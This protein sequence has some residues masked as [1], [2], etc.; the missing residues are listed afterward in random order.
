[1]AVLKRFILR[2]K[3][4]NMHLARFLNYD[5]NLNSVKVLFIDILVLVDVVTPMVTMVS[6]RRMS[7][8]QQRSDCTVQPNIHFVV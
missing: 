6:A 5:A 2:E 3:I 8:T 1:M 4:A 7:E